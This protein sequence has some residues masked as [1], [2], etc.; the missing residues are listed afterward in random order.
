MDSLMRRSLAHKLCKQM[1]SPKKINLAWNHQIR[2]FRTSWKTLISSKTSTNSIEWVENLKEEDRSAVLITGDTQRTRVGLSPLF[3]L[4]KERVM[5]SHS[6][7]KVKPKKIWE[8]ARPRALTLTLPPIWTPVFTMKKCI[9]QCLDIIMIQKQQRFLTFTWDQDLAHI[10]KTRLYLLI[11]NYSSNRSFQSPKDKLLA[12][13]IFQQPDTLSRSLNTD[14]A[15]TPPSSS[16]LL[17]FQ[18][19]R[20]K[21]WLI[22]FW[23]IISTLTRLKKIKN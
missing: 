16:I 3:C 2:L 22:R 17:F 18:K 5:K 4:P 10:S 8:N 14:S 7:W 6:I 15:S 13:K 19:L 21:R 11:I 12:R 1:H 20:L 9:I 23:K